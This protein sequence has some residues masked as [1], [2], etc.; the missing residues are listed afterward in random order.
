MRPIKQ[1]MMKYL[2]VQCCWSCIKN[3][4]RDL[5]LYFV[6]DLAQ[7]N[8]LS[9]AEDKELPDDQLPSGLTPIWIQLPPGFDVRRSGN[10]PRMLERVEK[11]PEIKEYQ[12]NVIV[13]GTDF[14]REGGKAAQLCRQRG[15]KYHHADNITGF[16]AK[17]V[18]LLACP[19]TPEFITR[20]INML[21]ILSR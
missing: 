17:C 1:T 14:G 6:Q 3:N 13:L 16:E 18:V 4:C 9:M 15:W 19:L 7:D 10:V 5:Y 21:V 2:I 12:D 20:G 11:I 8:H